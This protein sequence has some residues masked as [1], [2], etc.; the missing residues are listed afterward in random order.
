ML[1]PRRGE[2]AP[3][4]VTPQEPPGQGNPAHPPHD[5]L[6]PGVTRTAWSLLA[7]G[8][9]LEGYKW[10]ERT[11]Q[12]RKT[13]P[14]L[15]R[16]RSLECVLLFLFFFSFFL[17]MCNKCRRGGGDSEEVF[18]QN[19]AQSQDR[20][21]LPDRLVLGPGRELPAAPWPDAGTGEAG[22]SLHCWPLSG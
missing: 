7:T 21:W 17:F 5:P 13:S 12:S 4:A 1:R 18:A 9:M 3:R 16:R 19:P 20:V 14:G 8:A 2:C 22:R 6:V 11:L 10:S 15:V